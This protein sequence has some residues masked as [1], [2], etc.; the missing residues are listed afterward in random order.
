MKLVGHV[1]CKDVHV[2]TSI[3]LIKSEH[4]GHLG[5]HKKKMFKWILN[6]VQV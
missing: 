4:F 5:I 2:Y 6:T 3:F 1:A